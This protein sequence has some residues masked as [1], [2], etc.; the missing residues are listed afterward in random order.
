MDLI[1]DDLFLESNHKYISLIPCNFFAFFVCS[2]A[3]SSSSTFV[4]LVRKWLREH[5]ARVNRAHNTQNREREI[6]CK[7]A[8]ARK[9]ILAK[10]NVCSLLFIFL[11]K[12]ILFIILT[13]L[14]LEMIRC[15]ACLY[16]RS[17]WSR[18][19]LVCARLLFMFWHSI[20]FFPSSFSP[21]F[22]RIYINWIYC[23]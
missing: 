6:I 16:A 23:M 8:F 13:H 18:L 9:T 22:I 7:Q 17:H 21:L 3:S 12:T 20:C 19:S 5:R 15:P 2:S 11:M 14:P 10:C 1:I 4:L